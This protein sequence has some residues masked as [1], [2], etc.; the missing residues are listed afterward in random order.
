MKKEL[1]AMVK[2][3]YIQ[4]K[5]R[6]GVRFIAGDLEYSICFDAD[7]SG[8][9]IKAVRG[10]KTVLDRALSKGIQTQKAFSN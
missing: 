3:E 6:D 2:S 10:G 5:N 7:G 4:D 1:D 8:G 9:H